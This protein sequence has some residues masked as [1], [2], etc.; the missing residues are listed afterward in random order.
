[1]LPLMTLMTIVSVSYL[2]YSVVWLDFMPVNFTIFYK[3]CPLTLLVCLTYVNVLHWIVRLYYYGFL[4]NEDIGL[5]L[6]IQTFYPSTLGVL[7]NNYKD[8]QPLLLY[9]TLFV[10]LLYLNHIML[11][12]AL[13]YCSNTLYFFTLQIL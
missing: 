4:V 1:M 9:D 3:F 5:I 2:C 12:K 13:S 6:V 7:Y 11:Y 10:L 8:A